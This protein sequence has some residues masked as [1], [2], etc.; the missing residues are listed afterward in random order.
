MSDEQPIESKQTFVPPADRPEVKLTPRRPLSGLHVRDLDVILGRPIVTRQGSGEPVDRSKNL[1]VIYRHIAKTSA[2]FTVSDLTDT[3]DIQQ[4]IDSEQSMN[5]LTPP[6]WSTVDSEN[7]SGARLTKKGGEPGDPDNPKDGAFRSVW[8]TWTLPQVKPGTSGSASEWHSSSWVGL[9]GG[10]AWKDTL[11]VTVAAKRWSP[12]V[13][14]AGFAHN[15]SLDSNKNPVP[16]YEGWYAWDPGLEPYDPNYLAH[17]QKADIPAAAGDV[18]F[19][20]VEYKRG[21]E[22]AFIEFI[23]Y[24]QN[25]TC[26]VNIPLPTGSGSVDRFRGDTIEWVLEKPYDGRSYYQLANYAAIDFT[27]AAGETYGGLIVI[28]DQRDLI[29]MPNSTAAIVSPHTLHVEYKP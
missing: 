23:N 20:K 3:A 28:P 21:V 2:D 16:T 25:K 27:S 4:V 7:W 26:S 8:A 9:G 17:F 22:V 29:N 13:L 24:T 11:A 10:G 5:P 14:Q 12:D 15:I 18:V 6:P 1:P 19:V